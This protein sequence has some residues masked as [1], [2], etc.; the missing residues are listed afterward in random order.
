MDSLK[1]EFFLFPLS[2]QQ[3]YIII[4][5]VYNYLNYYYSITLSVLNFNNN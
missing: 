3:S 4:M 5:S 1:L 2:Q